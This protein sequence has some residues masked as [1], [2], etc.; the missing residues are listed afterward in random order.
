[1]L[2]HL[3]HSAGMGAMGQDCSYA[4]ANWELACR[5]ASSGQMLEEVAKCKRC[6]ASGNS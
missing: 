6:L 5:D 2:L 3:V 4:H 1:M